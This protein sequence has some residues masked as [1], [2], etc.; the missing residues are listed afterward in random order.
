MHR[1]NENGGIAKSTLADLLLLLSM[2]ELIVK[3]LTMVFL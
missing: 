3:N 2:C 1:K